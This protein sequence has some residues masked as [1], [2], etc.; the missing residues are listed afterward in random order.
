MLERGVDSMSLALSLKRRYPYMTYLAE[1]IE[2]PYC[3]VPPGES[4]RTKHGHRTD[5]PHMGRF[6]EL[7][8]LA[9]GE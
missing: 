1:V 6:D 3:H 7:E 4:C 2:C 9:R 8:R 5:V